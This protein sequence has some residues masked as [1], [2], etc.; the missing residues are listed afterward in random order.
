MADLIPP[1]SKPKMKRTPA[2]LVPKL[3]LLVGAL[4]L[5]LV[6]A[7]FALRLLNLAPELRRINPQS[8]ESLFRASDNPYL[9]YLYKKN[10]RYDHDGV[11]R[12]FTNSQGFRDTEH[13]VAK[14]EGTK[15]ILLL[16]DSVVASDQDIK[17]VDETI[18]GQLEK[19]FAPQKIEVLN[20]GI[21]GYCTRAEVELLKEFGLRYSPD[22]VIFLFVT[23]DYL[24][25]NTELGRVTM[26]PTLQFLVLRSHLFRYLGVRFNLF[27]IRT[28]VGLQEVAGE[29]IGALHASELERRER[30]MTSDHASSS[31]IREHLQAFD[32]ERGP[33][34]SNVQVALP[35]LKAL[36]EEHGFKTLIGHWPYFL[37][38]GILDM[39]GFNTS[40]PSPVPEEESLEI[41]RLAAEHAIPSFR[42]SSFFARDYAERKARN[43]HGIPAPSELYAPDTM[44][45]GPLGA[46][47]AADAIK[48]YLDENPHLLQ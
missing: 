29:W 33:S 41:E 47:V 46:R 37:P 27:N 15:R 34:E 40:R 39:E 1:D 3:L 7:E 28:H 20:L 24:N 13:S 5:S 10:L 44:H 4:V 18:S 48:A 25:L 6:L 43:A 26:T 17:S 19:L 14:P 2:R 9:G 12:P 31:T 16:G 11:S 36:G 35:M 22:L 21:S 42:L 45:P 30:I 23:N 38:Q 8:K 32:K